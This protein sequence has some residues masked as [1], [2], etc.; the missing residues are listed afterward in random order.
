MDEIHY[1]I[2][3]S[4]NLCCDF[5]FWDLR[6]TDVT[7][8]EKKE[9]LDQIIDSG[10]KKITLSGGEPTCNPDLIK[11]LKYAHQIGLQT[12]L[13]TNGLKIN[14]KMAQKIAPYI[15]RLSLSLDGSTEKMCYLMRS[16]KQI[17]SH[18]LELINIFHRL[19]LDVNVK[20]LVSNKNK[21]DLMSIGNL[22]QNQPVKYWSLLEFNPINR[23]LINKKEHYLD[24][25][26]FI[27]LAMKLSDYFPKIKIKI[28]QPRLDNYCFIAPNGDLYTYIPEVGDKIVGN[29]KK[30]KLK[31][32]I[33]EIPCA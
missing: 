6:T 30:Q 10:L 23:G 27:T 1:L 31:Y 4:C 16:N 19:H 9:I 3:N 15:N 28:R 21:N 18:T 22:L 29:I 13:H 8:S 26:E 25:E 24:S 11:V 33:K 14:Q 12:V 7:F 20:T 17:F 32:L 5:C 2:G